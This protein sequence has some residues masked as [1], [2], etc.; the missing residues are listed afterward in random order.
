MTSNDRRQFQRLK[1]AKPLMALLDGH[2]ALVL[3]IGISGA[4][5]EHYGKLQPGGRVR[6]M[7]R[8]QGTDVDFVCTSIRTNILREKA[9]A[10][11]VVSQTALRFEEAIGDATERLKDMMATFVGRI[12][13]AQKANAAAT[14]TESD[15]LLS[16]IGEAR[17]T[18]TSGF[19]MYRLKGTTWSRDATTSPDQPLDGFTVA[20]YEDDD[21]LEVLCRAYERTDE[22]GRQMIRIIAE[23]SAMSAKSK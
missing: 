2:N 19:V 12:L 5:I 18:R 10:S 1:L 4:F 21:E 6:L 7:F 17:R 14:D 3:D 13:A 16:K 20:A 15:T 22:D 9:T 8:W 11:T 23:L